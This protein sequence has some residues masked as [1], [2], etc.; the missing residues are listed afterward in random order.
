MLL[1]NLFLSILVSVLDKKT[2]IALKRYSEQWR[3]PALLLFVDLREKKETIRVPDGMR[4]FY[5]VIT[6]LNSITPSIMFFPRYT[7]KPGC[8]L[9]LNWETSVVIDDLTV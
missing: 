4:I 7:G 5:T 2:A 8:F 1:D 6:G 3:N 9:P